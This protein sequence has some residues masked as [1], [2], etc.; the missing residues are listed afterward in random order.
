M[1]V[2]P[3]GGLIPVCPLLGGKLLVEFGGQQIIAL[4]L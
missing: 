1:G 3:F 4:L 2:P